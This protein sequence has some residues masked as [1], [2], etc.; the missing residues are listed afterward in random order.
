MCN[1]VCICVCICVP[2][3]AFDSF[4]LCVLMCAGTCQRVCVFVCPSNACECLYVRAC[5]R[6][7]LVRLCSIG[8]LACVAVRVACG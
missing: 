7:W 2:V 3:C 1:C 4:E 6:V 5:V 8:L